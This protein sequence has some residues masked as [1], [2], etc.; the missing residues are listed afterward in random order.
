MNSLFQLNE[1]RI[2]SILIYLF[3]AGFF[4][5]ATFEGDFLPG[6]LTATTI[7]VVGAGVVVVVVVVV[8]AV[9]LTALPDIGKV[10][11][12]MIK[13]TAKRIIDNECIFIC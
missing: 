6:T 3:F 13:T 12:A 11:N 9:C 2:K 4:F 7:F 10:C 5:L 8:V 1:L